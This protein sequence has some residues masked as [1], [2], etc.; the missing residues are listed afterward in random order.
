M[1]QYLIML[2]IAFIGTFSFAQTNKNVEF[3]LKLD[4]LDRVVLQ[5]LKFAGFERSTHTKAFNIVYGVYDGLTTKGAFGKGRF[6]DKFHPDYSPNSNR[7]MK[8]HADVIL[9]DADGYAFAMFDGYNYYIYKSSYLIREM[10]RLSM[11]HVYCLCNVCGYESIYWGI[12]NDGE[13]Y[14]ILPTIECTFMVQ[15][16]PDD[17]WKG[18][19]QVQNDLRINTN[20]ANTID[21]K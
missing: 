15:D 6:L 20:S 10:I 5:Q 16:C 19:F 1:K 3:V 18:L 7:L 2:V 21:E 8:V 4:T 9:S 17:V 14:V 11:R 12:G 13:S